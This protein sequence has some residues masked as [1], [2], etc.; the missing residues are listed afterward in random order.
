[1][2]VVRIAGLFLFVCLALSA[3]AQAQCPPWRPC[4][5]GNTWGGNRLIRQGFYGADFR[6]ACACHDECLKTCVSRYECDRQFLCN[7]YA[8]CDDSCNPEKCRHKA[9]CYYRAARL[10][11]MFSR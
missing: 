4:G 1:M 3:A 8:A 2:R 10:A 7:M 9:R 11:H 6:P 5:P